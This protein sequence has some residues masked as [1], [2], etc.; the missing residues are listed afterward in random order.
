MT[1]QAFA[2]RSWRTLLLP[3]RSALWV[4]VVEARTSGGFPYRSLPIDAVG[5]R[6][7]RALG[8]GTLRDDADAA[9]LR[10]SQVRERLPAWVEAQ[11]VVVGERPV[12]EGRRRIVQAPPRPPNARPAGQWVAG[13]T[14]LADFHQGISDADTRFDRAETTL[15]HV[16]QDP[17]P[18][19]G[20]RTWGE[21]IAGWLGDAQDVLQIGPGTGSV[22]AHL[23]DRRL[24][25][26]DLSPA[27]LEAQAARAPRSTGVLGSA[28]ALPFG[29][30]SF[31]AVVCN[32]VI[33]DLTAAPDPGDWPISPEPGQRLFNVGAFEAIREVARVLRPGGRAWMSEFGSP[34]ELPVETEQLDHPEVS[35]HFGQCAQVAR[36][37]GLEVQ[38]VRVADALGLD[39]RQRWLWRG[40]WMAVRARWPSIPARAW[41]AETVPVPEPVEGLLDVPLTDEGPGPLP[42]RFWALSLT[43][44]SDASGEG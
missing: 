44:L 30:A 24:T 14:Q 33:A 29:D 42:G 17:H 11:A 2:A 25:R 36:A 37:C 4:P 39:T 8:T 19:L 15:A 31:D 22:S 27:L 38:V 21:A 6:L 23:D 7:W 41:T 16:F 9:G 13:A 26:L 35:I 28:T 32:E 34:E 18:A 12:S 1:P 43:R 5:V 3:S 40:S 20:G 10:W